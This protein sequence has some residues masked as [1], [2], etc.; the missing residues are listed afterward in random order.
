MKVKDI[1]TKD[2]EY[3]RADDP[4]DLI[5]RKM[6]DLNVGAMPVKDNGKALGILTDRDI[7]VRAVA[8]GSDPR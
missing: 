6:R 8:G 2:P 7:A 4:L 1:M 5:A 3:A